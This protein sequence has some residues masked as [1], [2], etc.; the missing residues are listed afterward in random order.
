MDLF[1]GIRRSISG[2][3]GIVIATI[4]IFACGA[5]MAFFLSPQAALEWR[6]IEALP[7]LDTSSFAALSA[8]SEAAITGTLKDNDTLTSDGLV[9]Y[10]KEIWNVSQ[11]SSSSSSTG[12]PEPSGSW[13]TLESH[14]PSLSIDIKGGAVHTQEVAGTDIGGSLHTNITKTS[15]NLTAEYDNSPLPDK[16]IRIQGF[17]N[18]DLVTVV[19]KKGSAGGLIPDRLYGGDRVQLVDEIHQQAQTLFGIGVGMMICA[20]IFLVVALVGLFFGRRRGLFG[21]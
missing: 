14:F 19:G 3:V 21:G 9:A 4:G 1:G 6:R 16:S 13:D 17:T 2:A 7:E 18:G 11:S 15:S 12:T 10:R 8:G 5:V 20:P